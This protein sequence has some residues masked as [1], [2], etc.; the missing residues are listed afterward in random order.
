VHAVVGREREFESLSG[1]QFEGVARYRFRAHN[2]AQPGWK[3][4]CESHAATLQASV[5]RRQPQPAS[6]RGATEGEGRICFGIIHRSLYLFEPVAMRQA[7]SA[8]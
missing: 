3:S 6:T 2:T 8:P 5:A 7:A 1:E 4:K